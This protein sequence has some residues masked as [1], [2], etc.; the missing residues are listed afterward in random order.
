[1]FLSREED[2]FTNASIL[3][4][5]PQN[6]LPFVMG[7]MKFTISFLLN[8]QILHIYTKLVKICLVVHEK[9][10]GVLTHD[11]RWAM[12]D[13]ERHPI[14]KGDL[15]CSG[16]IKIKKNPGADFSNRNQL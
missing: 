12:D 15:I 8:L 9:N 10:E 16:E 3:H 14:A 13:D 5:L 6:Y 2:F 7:V 1:M 4:F 11:G